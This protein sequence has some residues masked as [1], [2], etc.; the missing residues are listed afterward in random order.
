MLHI[1][2]RYKDAF[3]NGDWSE[4]ECYVSSVEQCKKIYG[5]DN[6]DCEYEI[7]EV[8]EVN[9]KGKRGI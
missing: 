4:Q 3:T 6:G 9:T 2:F 8:E 1:R 5:L 7:I